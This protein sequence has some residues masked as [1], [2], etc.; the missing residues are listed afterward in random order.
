MKFYFSFSQLG[1]ISLSLQFLMFKLGKISPFHIQNFILEFEI[2]LNI[3]FFF[4]FFDI[5]IGNKISLYL[6]SKSY[7]DIQN[8]A[9]IAFLHFDIFELGPNISIF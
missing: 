7:F 5:P 1:F 2:G 3:D 9:D 4:T 6:H 8:W